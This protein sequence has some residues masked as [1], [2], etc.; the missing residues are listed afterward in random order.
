[1]SCTSNFN[2]V[3]KIIYSL[4]LETHTV[5]NLA[6]LSQTFVQ[7]NKQTKKSSCLHSI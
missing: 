2:M 1:M 6:Q 5:Y 4:H 7:I 3:D